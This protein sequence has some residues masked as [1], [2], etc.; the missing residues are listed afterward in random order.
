MC[1]QNLR[2]NLWKAR[3]DAAA[4]EKK[5][6]E[7]VK[8]AKKGTKVCLYASLDNIVIVLLQERISAARDEAI[9]EQQQCQKVGGLA[10][11]DFC[12]IFCSGIPEAALSQCRGWG[13]GRLVE[14]V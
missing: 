11:F 8:E 6:T 1:F 9:A 10:G 7:L 12:L 13:R 14:C 3:D 5:S 2:D 4:T